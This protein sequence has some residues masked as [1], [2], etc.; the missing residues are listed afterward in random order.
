[1]E[2]IT[3]HSVNISVEKGT[4]KKP[5]ES[6]ELNAT[7]VAG[8]AHE[9][10]SHRQ[11]SLLGKESIDQYNQKANSNIVFGEFAENITT[12]GLP[13]YQ[14]KVLDRLICNEIV[15]EVTQIGKKCH[16]AKCHIFVQT[17]DCVMPREGIFCRVISGGVL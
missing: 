8:D 9:G 11:V 4:I 12:G 17:G 10:K 7:G 3:I 15:L 13:L 2:R 14:M 1:M 6:I 16:G 5:C